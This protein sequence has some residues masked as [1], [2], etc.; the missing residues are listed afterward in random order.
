MTLTFGTDDDEIDDDDDVD[1]VG[2]LAPEKE[3]LHVREEDERG[4]RRV[5]RGAGSSGSHKSSSRCCPNSC[6]E[7]SE[8]LAPKCSELQPD[9]DT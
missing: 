2:L 1:G 3:V 7:S 5:V 6:R 9:T 8:K 4:E